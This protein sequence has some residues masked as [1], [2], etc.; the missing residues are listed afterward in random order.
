MSNTK[1][2]QLVGKSSLI[3]GATGGFGESL[4]KGYINCG[5]NVTAV[6]RKKEKL[7]ALKTLGATPVELDL[8]NSV[9]IKNF[10]KNCEPFDNIIISHG[11]HGARPMRMLTPE[12]SL[13]VIQTNLIS[14]LDLLSN[15]LRAKKINSP[16]RIIIISSVSA[17]MGASTA[18][19]YA[20]AKAGVESAARGLARDLLHKNITVNCIAPAAIETPLFENS[21]SPVLDEKNYPLGIGNVDDVSAAALFLSL[22]GSKYI[23]GESIILDGGCT[24]LF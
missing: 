3:T 1:L 5:Q 6:G 24:W 17:H 12:Y 21:K 14:V 19:P 22:N 13:S 15:L 9:D 18:I 7:E 11:I 8:N 20:A 10:C 23:T 4:V 2:F 16:G